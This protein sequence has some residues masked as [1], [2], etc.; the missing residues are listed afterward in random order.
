[1]QFIGHKMCEIIESVLMPLSRNAIAD[2][3]QIIWNPVE[4]T[5]NVDVQSYFMR[6][7]MENFA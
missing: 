3:V 2:F 6:L 5:R 7:K 4:H 1:M